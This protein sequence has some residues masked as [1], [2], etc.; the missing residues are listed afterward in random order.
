MIDERED[1]N[2]DNDLRNIKHSHRFVTKETILNAMNYNMFS[3]RNDQTWR[4][5]QSVGIRL[6]REE[7]TRKETNIAR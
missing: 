1:V 4:Y 2:D 6:Y 5:H 7:R 3:E